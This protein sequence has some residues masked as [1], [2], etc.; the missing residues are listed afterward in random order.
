VT[1]SLR[2]LL[3]TFLAAGC[4]GPR[5]AAQGP[6]PDEPAP[7]PDHGFA[8]LR[9]A[10]DDQ[11]ARRASPG[12]ILEAAVEAQKRA[13]ELAEAAGRGEID[14]AEPSEDDFPRMV[15]PAGTE[16]MPSLTSSGALDG[17]VETLLCWAARSPDPLDYLANPRP[18]QRESAL[19]SGMVGIAT[20]FIYDADTTSL[21]LRIE[22]AADEDA[23][24]GSGDREAQ[25]Q[26]LFEE[27]RCIAGL[28][29]RV[30]PTYFHAS[31]G[32]AGKVH[33]WIQVDAVVDLAGCPAVAHIGLV[34]PAGGID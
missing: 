24:P 25:L 7:A 11:D 32:P 27:D 8:V 21:M 28:G 18:Y 16:Y 13:V 9:Q 31:R 10:C 29:K 20:P 3:L 26:A 12:T 15:F 22:V 5:S 30:R 2:F 23:A 19:V 14:P 4:G 6:P 34:Q 17:M 1:S 33:A